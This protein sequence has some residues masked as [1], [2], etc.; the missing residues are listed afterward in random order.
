MKSSFNG[1]A[2]TNGLNEGLFAK[3]PYFC[4]SPLQKEP[5]F[6]GYEGK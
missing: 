2:T 3:E 4:G 5:Y 1:V 6:H